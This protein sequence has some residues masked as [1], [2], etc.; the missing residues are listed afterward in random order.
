M[1]KDNKVLC[2]DLL[3]KLNARI[4][5]TQGHFNL[6]DTHLQQFLIDNKIIIK[7]Y[8]KRNLKTYSSNHDFLLC[9]FDSAYQKSA[10]NIDPAHD[11]LRHI[12]NSIA[13]SLVS[14]PLRKY[15]FE[16]RDKNRNSR[17]TMYAKISKNLLPSLVDE[18]IKTYR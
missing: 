8:G 6:E 14:T 17:E 7:S 15:Y 1:T 16:L 3:E 11:I 18:I 13:H 4:K 12:R 9:T 10:N 5:D 2:M